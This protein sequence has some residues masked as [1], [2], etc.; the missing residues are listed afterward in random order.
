M[1]TTREIVGYGEF[2]PGSG[3]ARARTLDA[4]DRHQAVCYLGAIA[5]GIVAGSIAPQSLSPLA[6]AITPLLGL[7]LYVTFL[8]V[9][10]ADLLRAARGGRFGIAVLAV[11]FVAAPL[12]VAALWPIVPHDDAV[13]IGVLLVLL[14]PCVDY[15]I[16]FTGLAGGDSARLLAMTPVLLVAQMVL[17][18]M[19]LWLFLGEGLPGAVEIRPFVEAFLAL[20][21]APL[22]LA[23]LTQWCS[24]GRRVESAAAASMVPL[25]MLVLFAVAGSQVPQL[26]GRLAASMPVAAVYVL[27]AGVMAVAGALAGRALRLPSP[28]RRAVLFSGVTRNSLVVLP[29][30]LA[31][32]G[33]A[34]SIAAA[35]VV[36]QTLVELVVMTVLVRVVPRMVRS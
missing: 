21:V 25:M 26:D 3:S 30:A 23:W 28:Q 36:L 34:S 24:A 1:A 13:R 18:P 2:V 29:L 14:C 7:L 9:P 16:V 35:V 31:L 6:A 32:P 12:V 4:L 15:V 27:F 33:D 10:A 17:L 19:Y 20:I 8:Q 11:N 5:V 22:L